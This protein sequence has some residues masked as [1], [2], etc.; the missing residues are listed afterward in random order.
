MRALRT[1]TMLSVLALFG[2]LVSLP[3]VGA[4]QQLSTS[5]LN[6]DWAQTQGHQRLSWW[7]LNDEQQAA[8][9]GSNIPVL[10]P[11]ELVDSAGRLRITGGTDWYAA[12]FKGDDHA[13]VVNGTTTVVLLDGHRPDL[14]TLGEPLTPSR[15]EGI[16]GVDFEAFGAVYRVSVECY[17]AQDSRCA[18]DRY[19]LDLT[20]G[21]A[22]AEAA[23]D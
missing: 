18:E 7:S 19:V 5:R 16:V 13:V 15:G 10:L 21:L 2:L 12:S 6:V 9:R 20:A 3:S 17:W 14:P 1:G 22:F 23:R 11:G 4:A 8:V